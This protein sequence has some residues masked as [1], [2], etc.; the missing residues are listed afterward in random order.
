VS[1]LLRALSAKRTVQI[2]SRPQIR[3]LDN[4]IAQ[5]QVGQNVPVVTGV[6]INALQTTPTITRDNA[7]LILTVTPRISPDG[8]VVME[9]AAERSE[10]TGAGVPVF[11][12]AT[13]GD[14]VDAPIKDITTARATVSVPTGQTIVLGGIITR[15]DDTIERK[16][17]YVGDIPYVGQLFRYDSTRTVRRELLIFLTPRVIYNDADSELIKQV[18]ADRLHFIEHEAEKIHGPLYA[19]PPAGPAVGPPQVVPP[20]LAPG[21]VPQPDPTAPADGLPPGAEV[22]PGLPADACPPGVY[23]PGTLYN[24]GYPM[25][26]GPT[27]APVPDP[28]GAA[29]L[30]DM[31][32]SPAPPAGSAINPTSHAVG[33]GRLAGRTEQVRP[34]AK[35]RGI[36]SRK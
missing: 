24:D 14:T 22:L 20:V 18:E 25:M 1:V 34:V 16:V 35:K 36:L 15:N 23:P 7:G 12:N 13:T 3:T 11:V 27:P 28:A 26:P 29:P 4:Q 9:V 6:S 31:P 2:L 32:P 10:Y 21:A 19:V 30:P 5:V 8:Q 17:P 33:S